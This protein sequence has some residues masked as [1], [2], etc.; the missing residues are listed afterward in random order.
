MDAPAEVVLGPGEDTLVVVVGPG[1]VDVTPATVVVA[2]IE[3]GG[4]LR[5]SAPCEPLLAHPMAT[6][7]ST[8]RVAERSR[9]RTIHL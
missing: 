6:I 9:S 8:A 4:A 5:G 1:V 7:I 3:V 2:A